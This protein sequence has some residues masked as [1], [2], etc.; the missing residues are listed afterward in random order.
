TGGTLEDVDNSRDGA[1]RIVASRDPVAVDA[2]GASMFGYAP[3]DIAFVRN[4]AEAGLG[5]AD[6]QSLEIIEEDV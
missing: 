2:Y 3:E 4:A 6:W 5:I 1:R